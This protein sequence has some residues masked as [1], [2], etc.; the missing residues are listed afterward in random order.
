M[1]D[2]FKTYLCRLLLSTLALPSLALAL[3]LPLPAENEDLVGS[4]S[5]TVISPK[6]KFAEIA[7]KYDL[8]FFEL[9]EANPQVDPKALLP[10]TEIILPNQYLLPHVPRK[11]III[12]IATMRLYFFPEGEKYFYTYP[13]GI[14]KKNWSTPLGELKIIGKIK[15][16]VW[17]VPKSIYEYRKKN[18]DPIPRIIQSGPDNPLGY[19]ALRL[20][21]PTY[22]IHGTN[23]PSSVGVRSSAGCIHL[24]PEDIKALFSMVKLRTPVLIINQPYIAGYHMNKLYV[25]AHLPLE[26]DLTRLSHALVDIAA[27]AKSIGKQLNQINQINTFDVIHFHT[28]IPTQV[29]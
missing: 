3:K 11:G 7:R 27:L 10:G 8:G 12:N 28:G 22:L 2:I 18:K 26:E 24:Y 15:N 17:L 20:S 9:I 5:S 19:F 23:E 21:L 14:G 16:P 29:D 6:D 13:V 25:E 1:N 4:L